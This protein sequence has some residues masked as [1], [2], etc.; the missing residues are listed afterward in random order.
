MIQVIGFQ[1]REQEDVLIHGKDLVKYAIFYKKFCRIFL[2]GWILL[3]VCS[4]AKFKSIV[5]IKLLFLLN[6]L[7]IL[8]GVKY[9]GP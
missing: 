9:N 6:I 8:R 4:G 3:P 1:L 2:A 5:F 7:Y